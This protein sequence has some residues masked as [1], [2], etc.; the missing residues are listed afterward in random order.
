MT[1][2]IMKLASTNG[3]L[4]YWQFVLNTDNTEYSTTDLAVLETKLLDIMK[5]TTISKIKVVSEH[6]VTS[7]LTIE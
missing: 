4:A 7:D 1:Y 2:K 5:E 6:T 3:E